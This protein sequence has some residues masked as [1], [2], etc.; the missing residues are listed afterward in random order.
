VVKDLLAKV[1][2]RTVLYIVKL[3]DAVISRRKIRDAREQ[4]APSFLPL[5]LVLRRY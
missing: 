3:H 1:P 5:K 4:C 2:G